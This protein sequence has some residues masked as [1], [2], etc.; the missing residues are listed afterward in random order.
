MSIPLSGRIFGGRMPF[1]V[2]QIACGKAHTLLLIE[3]NCHNFLYSFGCNK[4]GQLG[5]AKNV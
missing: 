3:R 5:I 1:E 2:K 4:W